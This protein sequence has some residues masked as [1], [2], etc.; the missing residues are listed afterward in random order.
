MKVLK[1]DTAEKTIFREIYFSFTI[2]FQTADLKIY[3]ENLTQE[4]TQ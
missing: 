3:S 2:F 4:I 1:V